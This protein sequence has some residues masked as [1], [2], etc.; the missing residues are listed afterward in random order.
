MDPGVSDR[1]VVHRIDFTADG[2]GALS[3]KLHGVARVK[4]N[5]LAG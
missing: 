1:V 4:V 2:V 5:E 3:F